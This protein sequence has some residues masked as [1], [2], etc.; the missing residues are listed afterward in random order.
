MYLYK[1]IIAVILATLSCIVLTACGG[2]DAGGESGVQATEVVVTLSLNGSLTT[3]NAV[4]LDIDLPA[5]FI[6]A[7]A[8]DGSLAPGVVS[9]ADTM[10]DDTLIAAKYIPEITLAPGQL[11]TGVISI[12]GF[13]QGAVLTIIKSLAAD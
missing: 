4:D 3:I 6:L 7:T 12:Q 1:K 8:A 11:F 2:G 10:P 9:S 5:G 13:Q